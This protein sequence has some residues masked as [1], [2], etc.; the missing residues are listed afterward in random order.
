VLALAV[1]SNQSVARMT[2]NL[3]HRGSC[4]CLGPG[5]SGL[6][7]MSAVT[8]LPAARYAWSTALAGQPARSGGPARPLLEAFAGP[9]RYR[10]GAAGS[11]RQVDTSQPP[12]ETRHRSGEL[13]QRSGRIRRQPAGHRRPRPRSCT[14]QAGAGPATWSGTSR[15]FSSARSSGDAP[16]STIT[17]SKAVSGA[18][19]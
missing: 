5:S 11:G 14:P 18:S 15:D 12:L 13:V 7:W 4:S 8:Q 6:F 16:E 19:W 2:Q 3:S 17:R 1:A 10:R 9:P